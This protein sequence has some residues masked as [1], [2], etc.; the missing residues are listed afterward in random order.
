MRRNIQQWETVV[1]SRL[2]TDSKRLLRPSEDVPADEGATEF[3]KCFVDVGPTFEAN[4]KT[5]EVVKP[6]MSTFDNPAEFA[7]STAVFCAALGDYWFDAALTQPL[8]MR[9]GVVAA[10]GVD[11]F[12][13]LKR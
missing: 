9:F 1:P 12:G 13:L 6:R 7:Q 11:D 5:T 8:T 4:A 2:V 3:E 10:V